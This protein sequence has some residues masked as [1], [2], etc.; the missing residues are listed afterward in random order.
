M[1]K[2]LAA[3]ARGGLAP[4][5]ISLFLISQRHVDHTGSAAALKH[6]TSASDAVRSIDAEWLRRGDGSLRPL[7]G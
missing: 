6:G 1:P 2:I 3:L 5:G 7:T 4:S